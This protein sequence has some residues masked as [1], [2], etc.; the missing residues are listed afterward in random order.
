MD[1]DWWYER[2]RTKSVYISLSL[3]VVAVA[4][5]AASA[6]MHDGLSVSSIFVCVSVNAACSVRMLLSVSGSIWVSAR[7]YVQLNAKRTIRALIHNI[8]SVSV[9]N[10][11]CCLRATY[12]N[13]SYVFFAVVLFCFFLLIRARSYTWTA[14]SWCHAKERSQRCC[15]CFVQRM[16]YTTRGRETKRKR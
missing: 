4:V 14:E 15:C 13:F 6:A 8:L 2:K 12:V 11:F 7:K 1:W 10:G 16:R 9:L 5:A 3:F